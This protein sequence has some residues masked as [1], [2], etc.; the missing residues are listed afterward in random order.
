[1]KEI[2]YCRECGQ[3]LLKSSIGADEI[4][5]WFQDGMGGS[6]FR[7]DSPFSEKTGERNIAE[8]LICPSWKRFFNNH[9]KV[10]VYENE[11][12]WL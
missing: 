11:N 1:M 10:V 8:I 5:V 2:K 9:D 4:K 12:H 7:L 6:L 3:K